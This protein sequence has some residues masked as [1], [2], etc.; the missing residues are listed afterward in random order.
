MTEKERWRSCL[1]Q[2]LTC[3]PANVSTQMS[4]MSICW[5]GRDSM[6]LNGSFK[7]FK[8]FP[9]C[10]S[11]QYWWS[12]S[13]FQLLCPQA[14]FSLWQKKGN[15]NQN[16]RN[17]DRVF[18]FFLEGCC[19]CVCVW[20]GGYFSNPLYRDYFILFVWFWPAWP[21]G[22]GGFLWTNPPQSL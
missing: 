5:T 18:F 20:C 1:P 4:Q 2:T 6:A 8:Y 13:S 19:E 17:Q 15:N 22:W 21:Q 11:F 12:L 16:N 10:F 3:P 7:H 14:E 9:V